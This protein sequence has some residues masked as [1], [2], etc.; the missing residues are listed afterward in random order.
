MTHCCQFS[1]PFSFYL[2]AVN[3]EVELVSSKVNVLLYE[4]L[5]ISM[6]IESR[7]GRN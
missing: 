2:S 3:I 1:K 5:D 4:R 7:Q 6:G